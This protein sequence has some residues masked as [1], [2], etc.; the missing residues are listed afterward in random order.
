MALLKSQ[1]KE[2]LKEILL[3]HLS[4]EDSFFTSTLSVDL[5]LNECP[6]IDSDKKK[7][8]FHLIQEIV[9]EVFPLRKEHI[10]QKFNESSFVPNLESEISIAS[11]ESMDQ[12]LVY[13]ESKE[14][15]GADV[16]LTIRNL[17]WETKSNRL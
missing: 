6:E 8:L 17:F 16:P 7:S 9:D 11:L 14:F 10:S 13:L 3:S 15:K 1:G 2:K 12:L 5:F 4:E